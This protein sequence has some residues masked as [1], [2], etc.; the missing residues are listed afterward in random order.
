MPRWD[1]VDDEEWD[2]EGDPDALHDPDEIAL[3]PCPHCRREM[4][5]DAERCPSCGHYISREDAPPGPKPWWIVLGV[6]VC[7]YVVWT[8]IF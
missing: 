7:L 8:W 1:D 3:V 2:D 5:E 4:L 6:I